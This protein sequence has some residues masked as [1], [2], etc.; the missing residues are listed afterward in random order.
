MSRWACGVAAGLTRVR[1]GGLPVC[2]AKQMER[3]RSAALEAEAVKNERSMK[4]LQGAVEVLSERLRQS[5]T[6]AANGG[7]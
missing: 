3:N 2:V 6:V 7:A 5:E 4:Q 1:A